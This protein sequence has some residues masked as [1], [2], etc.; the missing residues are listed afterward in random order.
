MNAWLELGECEYRKI[1]D[2]FYGRFSFS[3]SIDPHAWPSINEPVPSVTYSIAKAFDRGETDFVFVQ[4]DLH[5]K[6]VAAFCELIS[7]S[8]FLYAL[9]WQHTCY[10]FYPH[11]DIPNSGD[12]TWVI[13]VLPDGDYSIFLAKDTSFGTFGHP[14]EQT[15]CVFGQ[16][17]LDAFERHRP[18]I[19]SVEVRRDG[20]LGQPDLTALLP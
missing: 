1:W 20:R 11:G 5:A 4:S 7:E 15:I 12:G 6:V 14:W 16:R 13:P 10:R 2:D 18:R 9:D 3:P 8:E 17:L 19:F